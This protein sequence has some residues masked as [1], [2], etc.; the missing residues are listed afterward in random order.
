MYAMQ[1]LDIKHRHSDTLNKSPVNT[2][3]EYQSIRKTLEIMLALRSNTGHLANWR[4]TVDSSK[5]YQETNNLNVSYE[6]LFLGIMGS[7][8]LALQFPNDMHLIKVFT[9]GPNKGL[10]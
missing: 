8:H 1:K 3:N 6:G 7:T 2:R 9:C 5:L 4:A 10:Q